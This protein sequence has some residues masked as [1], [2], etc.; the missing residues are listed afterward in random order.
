MENKISRE[1][2][3]QILSSF[4]EG[5]RVSEENIAKSIGCSVSS[6]HRVIL[7]ETLA[8]DEMLKQCGLLVH[9]GYDRYRK[10]TKA[11]KEKLSET[12]GTIGGGVLGFGSITAAISASGVAGLSAAG[13]TSGLAAIGGIVGGGM[14]AGVVVAAAIPIAAA[15]VGYGIVRGIKGIINTNKINNKDFDEFWEMKK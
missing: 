4:I 5:N 2:L 13:V 14:V 10:L 8:S 9:L 1:N 3:P 11:E 7:E 12:I 15:M 6:L